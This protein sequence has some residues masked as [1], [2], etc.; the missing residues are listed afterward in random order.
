MDI[1]LY[2]ESQMSQIPETM[3]V[4]QN[5]QPDELLGIESIILLRIIYGMY[6]SA[7][8]H[9]LMS[10]MYLYMVVSIQFTK[11]YTAGIKD[12]YILVRSLKIP[13]KR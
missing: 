3:P 8:I 10:N 2:I 6:K 7:V 4:S 1:F 11:K 9:F 5:R 13:V 12:K